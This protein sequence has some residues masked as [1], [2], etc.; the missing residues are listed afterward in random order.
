[1]YRDD[2]SSNKGGIMILIRND[3]RREDLENAY[4]SNGGRIELMVM[5]VVLKSEKWIHTSVYKQP[6]VTDRVC[7]ISWGANNICRHECSNIVVTGDI[8]LDVWKKGSCVQDVL[9]VNGMKIW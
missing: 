2:Q 4:N 8:S 9:H 1:M 6:K 7:S 3:N 5:E